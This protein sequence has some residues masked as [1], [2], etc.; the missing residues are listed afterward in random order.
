MGV[1]MAPEGA[2][3]S[4]FRVPTGH[5]HSILSRG[6]AHPSAECPA[7]VALVEEAQVECDRTDAGVGAGESFLRH[8]DAPRDDVLHRTGAHTRPEHPRE[9]EP[10]D[11]CRLRHLLQA[12]GTAYVAVQVALH[13]CPGA[14]AQRADPAPSTCSAAGGTLARQRFVVRCPPGWGCCLLDGHDDNQGL[15]AVMV[16]PG[17]PALQP[18]PCGVR[19]PRSGKA[20]S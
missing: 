14:V 4:R 2:M 20:A 13:G 19:V 1:W 3:R 10:A 18:L 8:F 7:E 9:V 12:Y 6:R 5:S 15:D 16:S 11:A 17:L